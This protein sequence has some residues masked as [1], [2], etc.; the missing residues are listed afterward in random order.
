MPEGTLTPL[1][2]GH[3]LLDLEQ[4]TLDRKRPLAL[5]PPNALPLASFALPDTLL[6]EQVSLTQSKAPT[7]Q[8]EPHRSKQP[9]MRRKD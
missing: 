6:Q 9:Y 4:F 8:L 5:L 2:S 3:L 7:G 1:S